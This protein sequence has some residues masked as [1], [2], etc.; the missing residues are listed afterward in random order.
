MFTSESATTSPL[1]ALLGRAT[2]APDEIVLVAGDTRLSAAGLLREA[3]RLA[4]SLASRGV[5]PGD[6][7]AIHM[8][9]IAE[10]AIAYLACFRLGAI[11]APLNTRFKT[12]EL[13]HWMERLTPA[14]YLGQAELYENFAGVPQDLLPD[15]RRF[16]VGATPDGAGSWSALIDG[17]VPGGAS[18]SITGLVDVPIFRP[19]DP[20]TPAVLLSTSGTTSGRGKLVVWTHETLAALANAAPARGYVPGGVRALATPMMHASG[21]ITL[22]SACLTPGFRL[23]LLPKFEP[24]LVLDAIESHRCTSFSGLPF[25][26]AAL[27]ER[28]AEEPRD[29]SSLTLCTVV[30]DTCPAEIANSIRRAF[31]LPLLGL[32]GSTEEPGATIPARR[33]GAFSRMVPEVEARVVDEAG[34]RVADGET[35]ELWLKSASTTPGYWEGPGIITRLP[36]GFFRTGDI[37]R[38][39]GEDEFEYIARGKDII[40]RGGSNISPIEVEEVLR[41][42]PFV[43]DAAVAGIPDPV[44][45]QRVGAVLVLAGDVT[46]EV[47]PAIL[48]TARQKLA[49]YKVPD[50]VVLA[51][52]LPRA[53]STK[54]DRRAVENILAQEAALTAARSA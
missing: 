13:S 14:I 54:I 43:I 45:G 9:N 41:T 18:G 28:Q 50:L 26:Y 39:T 35:G 10:A 2:A 49:D 7:V 4:A 1:Q 53:A 47:V 22:V 12:E 27:A 31:V 3:E 34:D 38:M 5:Q 32:W 6:R 46:D 37:V 16:S 11:A 52:A 29:V 8:Y 21:V 25:I 48:G 40:L 30:G 23:V 17:A 44:L 20:D 51:A 33:V 15:A 36:D 42:C 19:H 24:D